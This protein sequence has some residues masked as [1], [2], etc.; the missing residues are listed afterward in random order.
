MNEKKVKILMVG[1][2]GQGVLT[3]VRLLSEVLVE[4]GHKIV[5]GQL[6]GMAQR[7]GPV[8]SSLMINS[9]SA[10]IIGNGDVKEP[11]D[12]KR[13]FETGCDGVMIG[14][15]AIGNPWLFQQAKDYMK[16]GTYKKPTFKERIDIINE[17]LTLT[18]KFGYRPNVILGFRKFYAGYLK[19]IPNIA[20][21][22]MD[23]MQMKERTAIIDRLHL[24]AKETPNLT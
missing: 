23:I 10:P 4:Q 6:H 8:Q 13:M 17:H 9:G 16:T 1:T 22:R 3:A 7:G 2:G 14:R 12:V 18:E 5:S 19:G 15:A 24:F 21:L 20:K 11:E